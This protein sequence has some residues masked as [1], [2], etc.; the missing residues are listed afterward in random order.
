LSQSGIKS[1]AAFQL[2]LHSLDF[3]LLLPFSFVS[4]QK[5]MKSGVHAEKKQS[6]KPPEPPKRQGSEIDLKKNYPSDVSFAIF[7]QLIK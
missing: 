3:F 2:F 4:R 6:G 1:V 7:L 5:K